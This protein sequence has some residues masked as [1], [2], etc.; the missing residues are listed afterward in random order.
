MCLGVRPLNTRFGHALRNSDSRSSAQEWH[1]H[2][3]PSQKPE[4][5]VFQEHSGSDR[6]SYSFAA[7]FLECQLALRLEQFNWVSPGGTWFPQFLKDFIGSRSAFFRLMAAVVVLLWNSPFAVAQ[8]AK[9]EPVRFK[10]PLRILRKLPSR[11][12]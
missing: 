9:P 12:C 3:Q 11:F 5:T 7:S 4:P 2:H 8:S 10:F 6:L 1:G